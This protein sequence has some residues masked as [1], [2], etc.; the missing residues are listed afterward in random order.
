MEEPFM[1][2]TV[3]ASNAASAVRMEGMRGR[4]RGWFREN[5]S[6]L[7]YVLA[8]FCGY[9]LITLCLAA[10]G[11][12]VAEPLPSLEELVETGQVGGS[13]DPSVAVHYDGPERYLLEPWQRWD[14][15]WYVK[16]ARS[17]YSVEDGSS[18]FMPLYPLLVRITGWL[19][20]GEY[21][22]ASL[23]ISNLCAPVA[24]WLLL[25]IAGRVGSAP[26]A[27]RAI[28]YAVSFP[29]AFFLLAGYTESLFTMLVLAAFALAYRRM[30]FGVA[31]VGIL[32]VL[33]RLT[34]V[35]L[36]PVFLLMLWAEGRTCYQRRERILASVYLAAIPAT[37]LIYQSARL[38]YIDPRSVSMVYEE[39]WD[40][41]VVYPWTA[42]SR[43]LSYLPISLS[44]RALPNLTDLSMLALFS[45][46]VPLVWRR[47]GLAYAT[48]VLLFVLSGLLRVTPEQPLL[49]FTRYMVPVFPATLYLAHVGRKP[50]W[51]RLILYPC[52]ALQAYYV[53]RYAT[54]GFV[55]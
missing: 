55:H 11:L 34:G 25:G 48:V 12:F 9:R 45:A 24:L 44:L 5:R 1:A 40:S 21:L 8:V 42:I 19:L 31:L 43:S 4:V 29:T 32:V 6:S 27:R 7:G 36:F 50:L 15:L 46:L 26:F 38:A 18:V 54:W 3:P 52:W 13:V 23:L 33:T 17:G 30:W 20:G 10:M 28:L 51:N 37:F 16:I 53:V 35:L 41:T 22:T 2:E 14:T 49:G 39:L 47:Y